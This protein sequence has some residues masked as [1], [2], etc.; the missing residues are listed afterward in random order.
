MHMDPAALKHELAARL[1]DVDVLTA[2]E[3]SARTWRYFM[4]T[5]GAGAVVLGAAILGLLVGT[6]VASQT[7]Y[8]ATLDHLTEYATLKA[9]GA[10]NGYVCRVLLI[11]ALAVALSGYTIG[12]LIA[13]GVVYCNRD[14]PIGMILSPMLGGVVFALTLGM[15]CAAS[16]VAIR[17]VINLEP[18]L[19]CRR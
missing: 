5:T 11:Q 13:S 10:R 18:G 19:G 12:M 14:G 1:P 6:I 15:S 4:F 9:I 16:L 3:F 7:L 2:A 8:A 17:A